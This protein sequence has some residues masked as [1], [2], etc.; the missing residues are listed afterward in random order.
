MHMPSNA[1]L[2]AKRWLQSITRTFNSTEEF[3][4][5]PP[6]RPH[7]Q[8]YSITKKVLR[9]SASRMLL[10]AKNSVL[11][12]RKSK[13]LQITV[14]NKREYFKNWRQRERD[15]RKRKMRFKDRNNN[16]RRH[17]QIY[18]EKWLKWTKKIWLLLNK[19]L[20]YL[21]RNRFLTIK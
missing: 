9:V 13:N 14:Q 4:N 20:S 12:G 17:Y 6:V 1:K 8:H 21:K 11:L 19:K 5:N 16:F 3:Q 10:S 7:K 2:Y 18:A 15:W